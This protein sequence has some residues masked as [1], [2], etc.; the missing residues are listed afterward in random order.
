[1]GGRVGGGRNLWPTYNQFGGSIDLAGNFLDAYKTVV[2]SRDLKD[3]SKDRKANIAIQE[4][5]L[6]RKEASDKAVGERFN[7]TSAETERSNR[8]REDISGKAA[9]ASESQAKTAADRE[10]RLGKEY[11]VKAKTE[12]RK[13]GVEFLDKLDLSSTE[14]MV[15]SMRQWGTVLSSKIKASDAFTEQEEEKLM[16]AIKT[17]TDDIPDSEEAKQNV[18]YL[19]DGYAREAMGP[20]KYRDWKH[21]Q[22]KLEIEGLGEIGK[23]EFGRLKTLVP[24]ILKKYQLAMPPRGDSE[25]LGDYLIKMISSSKNALDVIDAQANNPD[26]KNYEQAKED[27]QTL[28]DAYQRMRR[29]AGLGDEVDTGAAAGSAGAP[30][31]GVDPVAAQVYASPR[32]QSIKNLVQAGEMTPEEGKAE[33]D[34]MI[35]AAAGG[36]P[37]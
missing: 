32:A 14:S 25:S 26:H 1:M 21:D 3:K 6:K 13:L 27:Q 16:Y 36:G 37:Q 11:G 10:T 19:L 9:A 15:A 30:P 23:V 20:E 4:G 12:A 18:M 7:T 31:P 24:M 17:M 2:L 28:R 35:A 34:A 33:I 5:E 29:L 22:E 8:A